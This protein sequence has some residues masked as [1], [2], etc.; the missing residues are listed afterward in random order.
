VTTPAHIAK[1][2]RPFI[3]RRTPIALPEADRQYVTPPARPV[4]RCTLIKLPSH[5]PLFEGV[6]PLRDRCRRWS[7]HTH[8][9]LCGIHSPSCRAGVSVMLHVLAGVRP[10]RHHEEDIV[11]DLPVDHLRGTP[12]MSVHSFDR[13]TLLTALPLSINGHPP[14]GAVIRQD[15]TRTRP[16]AHAAPPS[17]RS[18]GRSP[19]PHPSRLFFRRMT[20]PVALRPRA[21]PHPQRSTTTPTSYMTLYCPSRQADVAGNIG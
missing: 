14:S 2:K 15:A 8:R 16:K 1:D 13:C 20:P 19:A 10:Q 12:V 21:S 3:S 9:N 4:P 17:L 5:H 11:C 6:Q 7:A 18:P